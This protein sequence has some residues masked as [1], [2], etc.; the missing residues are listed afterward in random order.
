MSLRFNQILYTIDTKFLSINYNLEQLEFSYPLIRLHISTSHQLN[1]T[2]TLAL[3][4]QLLN[5][6]QL[7]QPQGLQPIRFL[8]PWNFPGKNTGVGCHFLLQFLPY[9]LANPHLDVYPK[10]I[11]IDVYITTC[12]GI[13]VS[14]ISNVPKMETFQLP[15]NM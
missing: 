5:C 15:K 12:T 14:F 10:E 13:L 3:V 4:V 7:L 6:V 1:H 8:C 2:L 11:Q 9:N